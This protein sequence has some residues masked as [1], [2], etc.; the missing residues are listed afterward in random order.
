MRRFSVVPTL[1][2]GMILKVLLPRITVN[3]KPDVFS[4]IVCYLVQNVY[5]KCLEI[6]KPPENNNTK[7]WA[8][9]EAGWIIIADGSETKIIETCYTPKIAERYWQ[10]EVEKQ[11]RMASAI[12]SMLVRSYSLPKAIRLARSLLKHA[13]THYPQTPLVKITSQSMED[14]M[15]ILDGKIQL[16]K[17]QVFEYI[18]AAAA[19]QSNPRQVV[20]EIAKKTFDY[21]QCRPTTWVTNDLNIIITEDV[22]VRNN[23]FV[24]AAAEGNAE[25][26]RFYL[27][28]GKLDILSLHSD[29]HYTALHAAADF[30]QVEIIKLILQTGL[31]LDI[32]DPLRGQTALHF[33]AES[34]RSE[35][36]LLLINGGANRELTNGE[37]MVPFQAAHKHG[38]IETREILKFLPPPVK[39]FE[40]KLN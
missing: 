12:A 10:Q 5:A 39:D 11:E 7:T 38:Y 36:A 34:G 40:V 18:K 33:A 31:S 20:I 2:D 19:R 3:Q 13:T 25:K 22:R 32:K 37:G 35:V 30:G 21:L 6:Y 24:M 28:E 23:L 1:T 15:I 4:E 26:F 14:I 27:E 29:L 9:V 17:Q 16:T 8:R